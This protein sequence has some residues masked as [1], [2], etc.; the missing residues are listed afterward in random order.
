MYVCYSPVGPWQR[1]AF[2]SFPVVIGY[3]GTH[4]HGRSVV[5]DKTENGQTLIHL[6]YG[7]MRQILTW[8]SCA[9]ETLGVR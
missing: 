5:A 7:P 3:L 9:A 2:F 1:G 4:L 6:T 8:R